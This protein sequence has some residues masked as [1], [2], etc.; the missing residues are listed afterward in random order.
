[1]PVERE[2]PTLGRPGA[3]VAFYNAN[4]ALPFLGA[5]PANGVGTRR[6]PSLKTEAVHT[7]K[8]KSRE[9]KRSPRAS[10]FRAALAAL[11]GPCRPCTNVSLAACHSIF[12]AWASGFAVTIVL[13]MAT[14]PADD[15][16]HLVRNRS[17]GAFLMVG[18]A[19]IF[20]HRV[21]FFPKG[22]EMESLRSSNF[23]LRSIGHFGD[24]LPR[25]TRSCR[26]KTW[27]MQT[28]ETR[29]QKSFHPFP[30]EAFPSRQDGHAVLLAFGE[31]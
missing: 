9:W 17:Q 10:P 18:V 29:G 12:R 8:R 21:V 22:L 26:A 24:Q 27:Q 20:L 25:I 23:V 2:G 13:A 6:V 3:C 15:R 11:N 19:F 1:M 28:L 5:G 7:W 16:A 4:G 31:I 30:M 14:T